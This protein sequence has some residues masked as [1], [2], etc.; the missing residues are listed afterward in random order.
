MIKFSVY[1]LPGPQGSKRFVG[2]SKSGRGIMVESSAKVKPWREAVKWAAIQSGARGLDGPLW[3]SMVFTIK[4][5]K[6]APKRKRTWPATKPDLS[7]LAR[8]TEDAIS[9]SGVWAD[10]ARVVE[11]LRLAKVYPGE[12][13]DA[14]DRPGCLITIM[15]EAEAW[16][17]AVA[18]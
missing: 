11:Y 2:K 1:G 4:K 5:P 10:D 9:D 3:V 17:M 12:D 16:P 6:S 13:R 14:L 7:K 15:T 8:S 18:A